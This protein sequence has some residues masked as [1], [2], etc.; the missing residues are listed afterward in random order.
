MSGLRVPAS[1]LK[2]LR[3]PKF[4]LRVPKRPKR[5]PKG[6]LIVPESGVKGL[7]VT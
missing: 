5:G 6:A 7:K 2:C 1:G 4:S 3:E